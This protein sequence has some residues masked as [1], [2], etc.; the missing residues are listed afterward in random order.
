MRRV[1]PGGNQNHPS[2]FR[3]PGGATVTGVNSSGDVLGSLT[4]SEIT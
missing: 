4:L 3:S 1:I 2:D